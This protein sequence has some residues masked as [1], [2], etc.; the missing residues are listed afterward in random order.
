MTLIGVCILINCI[1]QIKE[2]INNLELKLGKI[3]PLEDLILDAASSNIA[4]DKVLEVVDKLKRSGDIFEPRRG[5]IS[6]I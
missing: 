2:I 4:E 5:F 1:V 3:I 6:K